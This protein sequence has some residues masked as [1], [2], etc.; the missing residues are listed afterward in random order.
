MANR[1]LNPKDFNYIDGVPLFQGKSS[2]E[3]PKPALDPSP[4]ALE[5]AKHASEVAERAIDGKIVAA[6]QV[7]LRPNGQI[8]FSLC[9]VRPS[10]AVGMLKIASEAILAQILVK[11]S[12]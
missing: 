7:F 10:E 11:P 2:P 1:E 6:V 12:T 3:V 4:Q 9:N 8:E 5:L